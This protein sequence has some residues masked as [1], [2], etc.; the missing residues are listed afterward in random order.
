MEQFADGVALDEIDRRDKDETRVSVIDGQLYGALH[1]RSG[2][3]GMMKPDESWHAYASSQDVPW[4]V[5][6]EKLCR[7]ASLD[8]AIKTSPDRF[9]D[10]EFV[11][12]CAPHAFTLSRP[13]LVALTFIFSASATDNLDSGPH[14]GLTKRDSDR[15]F[16]LPDFGFWSWPEP[17]VLGWRDARRKA[18][19]FE[20]GLN[21]TAKEDKLVCFVALSS[22]P[23]SP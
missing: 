19:E 18:I 9:P 4:R 11:F 13:A 16:L 14:F 3:R 12:R 20:R 6:V 7:L 1:V 8:E 2:S 22:P 17:R 21:W 10:V 5:D 23:L 15:M